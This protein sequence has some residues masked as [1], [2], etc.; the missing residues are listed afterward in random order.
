MVVQEFVLCTGLPDLPRGNAPHSNDERTQTSLFYAASLS[1]LEASTKRGFLRLELEA[2][3]DADLVGSRGVDIV[4][5]PCALD[6]TISSQLDSAMRRADTEQLGL[7]IAAARASSS[8]CAEGS[9]I[10]RPL[11]TAMLVMESAQRRSREREANMRNEQAL[12]E[13]PPLRAEMLGRDS[14]GS[15]CVIAI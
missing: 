13:L 6:V 2:I 11:V 8:F 12:R 10:A 14:R 3:R 4:D 1:S 9:W 15:A 5:A 7:A